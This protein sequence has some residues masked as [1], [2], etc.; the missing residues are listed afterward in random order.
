MAEIALSI[1]LFTGIVMI[2]V[3]V[4]LVARGRLVE[5]GTVDI[6]VNDQRVIQAEVGYK[7]LA[8]L[9]EARIYL[10]AACGGRG[11]CGQCRATVLE[12]GGALLPIETAH[13]SRGEARRGERLAC[14]LTIKSELSISLPDE[15][16][17]AREIVCR[18][19]SARNVT[20]AI[21]EIVLELPP[22]GSFEHRAG[23]YVL[24]HCPAYRTRFADISVEDAFA[25]DW[26]RLGLD[27]KVAETRTPTTRAYSI[28][29]YPGEGDF[30]LLNIR[31]A[32]PPP[33]APASAP[34]GIV[35]SYLFG[36]APGDTV[37]VSGPFGDF[38]AKDSDAEMIFVG[39]G[40]G[41]APL[42]ALI[43]DQLERVG[44]RRR[45]SF[46][47]GARGR[48]DIYYADLFDRLAATHANFEWHVGL[49][50]PEPEADDIWTG[51]TGYIHEVLFREY[52]KEHPAPED[53]EY[54]L[55]GPPLM[56]RAVTLMLAELGVE[57][58]NIRY[59]DFGG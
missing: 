53:C 51:F 30:I 57:A 46:W 4:I 19:R 41:L 3:A 12:G 18:V 17:G 21:R 55:C 11:T 50:E 2:L 16:V 52:L 48:R 44:T 29:S 6:T 26:K 7:L 24:V 43:L 8:A 23:N 15:I 54:Y 35:S 31:L 47:Y 38:Y 56:T 25:E 34:P 1:A 36:L 10:A 39:G 13:I 28:A 59:D 20:T 42:R 5:T 32:L 14:Q 22:G 49:S 9:A 58:Q 27:A 40:V 45:M 33:G 37:T